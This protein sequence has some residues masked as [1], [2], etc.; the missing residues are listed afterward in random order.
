MHHDCQFT[1]AGISPYLSVS[2]PILASITLALV[3]HARSL[4]AQEPLHPPASTRTAPLFDFHSNFWVNL[5]QVLLHEA[6]LRAGKPDRRLQSSTPLSAPDM[7]KRDEANWSAAVN[8]YAAHFGTRQQVFDDQLIQI[9]DDL[10]SQPDDEANLNTTG[11]PPDVAAILRSA[12]PIYRKYWW[13]AHNQSNEKWITSQKE[14]GRDL[15]PKLAAAMTKD[16]HQQWPAAPIRVDVC[17]YVAA[18]GYAYTTWTH[19][20]T[21]SSSDPSDQGLSGFELLFH[22][23][24]HTFADTMMNALATECRAQHEDCGNPQSRLSP[25]WHAVLFYTSG[26]E[27]RRLLPPTE[28]ASFTPYAYA[29]G[30]YTRGNWPRYRVVLEK[31]WQAYLDG[32][33]S[34]ETAIHSMVADL[35]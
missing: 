19:H 16:L 9:N 33:L 8:F 4:R 6:L 29:N 7:D 25:L 30:V 13:P 24:S 22:E 14:G 34:F 18:I 27:L 23:A 35:Q 28:Q 20:T 3:L 5:H 26:V 1:K 15:G 31:D 32:K 10:A 12:A 17:Y 11:L 21:F 2:L